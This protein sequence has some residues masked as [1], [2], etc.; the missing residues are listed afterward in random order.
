MGDLS[1]K[2]P[3]RWLIY[4]PN[5]GMQKAETSMYRSLIRSIC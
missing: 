5:H 3:T 1:T 2:S 4:P